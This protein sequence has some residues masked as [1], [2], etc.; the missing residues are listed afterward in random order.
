MEVG[1]REQPWV[2]DPHFNERMRI[3]FVQVV[4]SVD[5]ESRIV[6][7]YLTPDPRRY[8][9][10]QKAG[11]TWY[12]DRYFDTLFRLEDFADSSLAGL[13]IFS[14]NRSINSA[15][16]YA[17][18]RKDAIVME[19]KTGEHQL[20]IEA[21]RPHGQLS[22]NGSERDMAFL[23]VDICGSTPY[24]R[25]D[26]QG[27]DRAFKIILEELGTV[28]GQFQGSLLKTTGDGFI[29]YL[30]GPSFNVL[31]DSTADLGGSLLRV[32]NDAIN[33]AIEAEGLQPLAIRIGAD[34]GPAIAREVRVTTTGYVNLEVTSDAL[35]RA[36]KIEES[37]KPNT[38]RI[39]Y[40]L[41]RQLHVQWLERSHQVAFVGD[42]VGI[43]GYQVFEVL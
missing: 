41:Y 39:G 2:Q 37:A 34:F 29:A 35:N 26:P 25:R 20:P 14:S 10:V 40:N 11:G 15:P 8:D 7:G 32:H 4:Q 38:F 5:K 27:F 9:Q 33:S 31:V 3:D 42:S 28:V 24:R 6:C 23:S 17:A 13:P 16:E 43:P 22:A 19:L 30:D 36:V 21:A 18:K 1:D 12:R